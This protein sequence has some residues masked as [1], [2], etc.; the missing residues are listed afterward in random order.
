MNILVACKI[1]PD[2]QDAQVAADGSLSFD[3]AHMIVSEYDL[4]AIEFAAQLAA[5]TGSSL[6]AIS[7]GGKRADDSKLKK[8][9]LARGIDE[10]F[11]TADDAC[12]DLDSAAT[13]AELEKLV[14][15]A[16]GCDLI[17]VGSGSADL[18]AKQ[19]GVHLA[20]RLG[21]P[22]VP[23]VV[24]AE[25]DGATLRCARVLEGSVENVAAPMPCVIS[26]LPEAA[27]PRIAGM[28]DI[29]AAGKKPMH[30]SAAENV[31][32]AAVTTVSLT[33]PEQADRACNVLDDLDAFV[34]AVKAAL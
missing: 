11:L 29:L 24:K 3:K 30:V 22:Y 1:I 15:A 14:Q 6:K 31:A 33:A 17:V 25:A 4:N 7:V 18:Y 5:A 13:A 32:D 28:K 8:G 10:L 12:A 27:Q 9:I 21:L 16:G 2:D 19:V 26:V 23:G 20:A 34:A